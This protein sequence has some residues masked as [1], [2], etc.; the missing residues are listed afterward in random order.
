MDLV[1]GLVGI[2]TGVAIPLLLHLRTHPPR[3][4]R[5][6]VTPAHEGMQS[7][8][9]REWQLTLWSSGRAAIPSSAFDAG[10]PIEFAFSSPVTM[11]GSGSDRFT[12]LRPNLTA[13]DTIVLPAQLLRR[14]ARTSFTFTIAEP[15]HLDVHNPI[16]DVE[17]LRDLRAEAQPGGQPDKVVSQSRRR[18]KI[19]FATFAGWF[20][21]AS[22]VM[23][24]TGATLSVLHNDVGAGIGIPGMLL[25]PVGI[26][27]LAVAGIRNLL[28]RRS[29][30]RKEKFPGPGLT[31]H[32]SHRPRA[33]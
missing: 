13:Q 32:E 31:S 11:G 1:V 22:F 23:F 14:D 10:R 28:R 15:F 19:T 8:N 21:L 29:E 17:I 4:L 26:I 25:T 18:A 9:G 5:Y 2:L 7:P 12:S 16:I 3:Q 27:L 24:A 33:T 20:T 6:A 30:K